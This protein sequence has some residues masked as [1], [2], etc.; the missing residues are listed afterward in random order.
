MKSVTWIDHLCQ[1]LRLSQIKTLTSIWTAFIQCKSAILNEIAEEMMHQSGIGINHTLKRIQRF[2]G[3]E[4]INQTVLYA[5]V[6]RFVW[7][8]LR[9]WKTIPIAIDWSFCEEREEWQV[10]AASVIVRG[11]GIPLLVWAFPKSSFGIYKSQNQV[12]EAFIN[13]LEELVS[14]CRRTRQTIVILADR[15]FAR[16]SLFKCIRA[17]NWHYVIRV[18]Q[19]VYVSTKQGQFQIG[20]IQLRKGELKEFHNITYRRDGAIAIPRLVAK[21]PVIEKKS[22]D[23]WFLVSSLPRQGSTIVDLYALRFTIEEDFRTMKSNLGWKNSR[24][25]KLQHYRQFLVLVVIAV[26]LCFFV[27]L[28]AHRKPSLTNGVVRRRK[29]KLDTS[30][31][32]T[33]IRLLR[34][35][36]EKLELIRKIDK[37]PCPI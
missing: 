14:P 24:I 32:V 10:L 35:T 4:R 37:M 17:L 30:I 1:G 16:P 36:L 6:T 18:K 11:R 31:T 15:G 7:R 19:N 28:A 33:G 27:G 21:R 23:P 5:N 22:L 3:N 25:K 12:E 9:H 34:L 8:R 29:G 2:L 26:L 20:L 13:E